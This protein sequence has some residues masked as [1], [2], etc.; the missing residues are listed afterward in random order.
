M[1]RAAL[2]A[3]VAGVVAGLLLLTGIV[4]YLIPSND[5]L[6]LPDGAHPVAPLVKVQGGHNSKGP[7]GIYFVDVFERHASMFESLFPWIHRGATL[8][9][10]TPRGK[11]T[12]AR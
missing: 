10:T 7:G 9:P 12:C 6:L 1:S 8:V 4:L 3:K 11:P 5:Y 2:P